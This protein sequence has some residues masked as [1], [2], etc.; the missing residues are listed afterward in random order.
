MKTKDVLH[1]VS[2]VLLLCLIIC[3]L[4]LVVYSANRPHVIVGMS[5]LPASLEHLEAGV[6]SILSQT[7][8]IDM[9]VVS[10]PYKSARLGIT[11]DDAKIP[12]S[13]YTNPRVYVQRTSDYGPATKFMGI[14]KFLDG[15][16]TM[17]KNNCIIVWCDDDMLYNKIMV[18]TYVRKLKTYPGSAVGI[19]GMASKT[20]EY[21]NT[22]Y[23]NMW[24]L[25]A[26]GGIACRYIDFMK[27]DPITN[28]KPETQ[29]SYCTLSRI[30]KQQFHSDDYMISYLLRQSG[31]NLV[32]IWTRTYNGDDDVTGNQPQQQS[33]FTHSLNQLQN[34]LQTYHALRV[35]FNDY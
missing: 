30:A 22:D 17:Y 34:H 28:F 5:T 33:Y 12:A 27:C 3:A 16:T 25:E 24:M 19:K 23:K 9:V 4:T 31:V 2:I 10:I 8:H 20:D 18:E 14:L 26:F 11:Y 29:E 13:L 7:Y 32:R 1:V 35:H 6:Q 21:L 15:C